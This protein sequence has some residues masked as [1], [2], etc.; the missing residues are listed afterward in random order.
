MRL[1]TEE[2][3][4]KDYAVGIYITQYKGQ[5]AYENEKIRVLETNPKEVK[6]V[7]IRAI[8]E[9]EARQQNKA[10]VNENGEW[11]DKDTGKPIK[12]E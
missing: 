5:G 12:Q 9:E 1:E 7:L 4:K 11:V 3:R 6:K 2:D 8:Q 10:V